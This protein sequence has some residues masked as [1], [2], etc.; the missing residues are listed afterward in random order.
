[1]WFTLYRLVVALDM[2]VITAGQREKKMAVKQQ[3]FCTE[4]VVQQLKEMLVKLVKQRLVCRDPF[5]SK[6]TLS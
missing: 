5:M 6:A 3:T 4:A 2:D 1:M